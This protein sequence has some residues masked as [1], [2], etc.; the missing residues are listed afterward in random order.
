MLVQDDC[1][2]TVANFNESVPQFADSSNST[3]GIDGEHPQA[4]HI[5]H[6]PDRG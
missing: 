4:A 6:G 1:A 3:A 2:N 5:I